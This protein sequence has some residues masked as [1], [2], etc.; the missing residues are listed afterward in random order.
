MI[1]SRGISRCLP[2][3]R[4]DVK[5][6]SKPSTSTRQFGTAIRATNG[7]SKTL[8]ASQA[9]GLLGGRRTAGVGAAAAG[10]MA[11]NYLRAPPQARSL[12]LWPWSSGLSGGDKFPETA[13]TAT[14]SAAASTPAAPAEAA[15]IP[16]VAAASPATPDLSGSADPASSIDLSGASASV[17][18]VLDGSHYLNLASDHIGYLRE[19]GLN[20]GWGP[21]S[22]AQWGIEHLHVWGGMPWWAAILGYAVVTRLVL[23]K[24]GIDAF[25]QQRKLQA[26]K[27]DPRGK[28]AFDKM[29]QMM[30]GGQSSTTELLAARSEVQ[31]LQRAAGIST[32]KMTLPMLQMPIG[33]GVF[34][35]TSACADLPVPSFETGGFMWLMDLTAPDPFYILPIASSAMMYVMLQHSMKMSADK[36]QTAMFKAVQY[37]LTPISFLISLKLNAALQLYFIASAGLQAMQTL[38]LSR[39]AVCKALGVEQLNLPEKVA[40]NADKIAWEAP[41]E[42]QTTAT[43]QK[44]APDELDVNTSNP[45]TNMKNTLSSVRG[46]LNSFAEKGNVKK[47]SQDAAAYEQRRALEEKERYYARR[48]QAARRARERSNR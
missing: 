33:I 19:L 37:V 18:D 48:E 12:S 46:K 39:P 3:Q 45:I 28:A 25:V 23:L 43:V 27:K 2:R 15:P 21:S 38:I 36:T 42:I 1:P 5:S 16:E 8:R 47:T 9:I 29:S 14:S 34:R 41:R 32:W 20:F 26:L 44:P 22:M 11:Q 4:L 7:G 13:D 24:P 31:R 35:V 40:T 10:L 6:L 30:S 17:G